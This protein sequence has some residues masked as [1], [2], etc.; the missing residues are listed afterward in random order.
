[1]LERSGV[2]I[3]KEVLASFAAQLK[4]RGVEVSQHPS[5]NQIEV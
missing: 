4:H 5:E 3:P 1:M 2:D